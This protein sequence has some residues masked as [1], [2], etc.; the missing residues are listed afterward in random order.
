M[1]NV[2]EER[3]AQLKGYTPALTRRNDH[4]AFWEKTIKQYEDC[5]VTVQRKMVDTPMAALIDI[6]DFSYTSF[7]DT[8]VHGWYMLPKGESEIAGLVSFP[9]YTGGRGLPED[10]LHLVTSGFAVLAIDARLQGGQTGSKQQLAYGTAKGWASQGILSPETSY[11]KGLLGDAYLAVSSLLQ[12]PEID[13]TRV[14][15]VGSSQGGG[16]ALWTAVLHQSVKVSA[17]NV[18]NMCHLH[19]GVLSSTGS[20]TEIAEFVHRYPQHY[21]QVMK[22]LTY[23][24]FLNSAHKLVHPVLVS[25]G[26]KDTVCLPETIFAAFNRIPEPKEINVYPFSGHSAPSYQQRKVLDFLQKNL[27]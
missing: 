19:K 16:M 18:P 25:V 7:D 17:A 11:Y 13:T 4:D 24:D 26:L 12:Q 10:H 1:L 8:L 20:L 21:D 6:Y 23:Y 3:I 14:G 9:G 5:T 27:G 15:V 2:V 22:T